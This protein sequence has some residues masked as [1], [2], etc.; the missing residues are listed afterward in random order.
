MVGGPLL[1]TSTSKKRVP[2]SARPCSRQR[3]SPLTPAPVR[4][5]TARPPKTRGPQEASWS[6]TGTKC[7]GRAENVMALLSG[8]TRSGHYI[9]EDYSPQSRR[10]HREKTTQRQ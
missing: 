2:P 9:E 3:P 8:A 4:A 7:G 5:A 6:S 1:S 10:G